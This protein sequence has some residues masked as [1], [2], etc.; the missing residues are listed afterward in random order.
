MGEGFG[1]PSFSLMKKAIIEDT[2]PVIEEKLVRV[3]GPNEKD[4]VFKRFQDIPDSFIQRLR[5]TTAMRPQGAEMRKVASIPE[6]VVAKW[7]RE[8]FDVHKESAQA[9]VARL[10]RE[11]L[12]HFITGLP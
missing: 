5:D 11:D 7:L 6:V 10:S 4:L 9:I 8:G 3:D 2:T 12:G 1:S